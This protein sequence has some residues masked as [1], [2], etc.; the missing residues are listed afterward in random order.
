MASINTN[1]NKYINYE[2]GEGHGDLM[3]IK[4]GALQ[5]FENIVLIENIIGG[6]HVGAQ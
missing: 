6:Y 1:A 3:N 2:I 4:R 5:N